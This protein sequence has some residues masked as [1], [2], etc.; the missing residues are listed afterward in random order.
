ME[1]ASAQ[2]FIENE[3]AICLNGDHI[4]LVKFRNSS[5]ERF[6]LV[7]DSLKKLVDKIRNAPKP[8]R[9]KEHNNIFVPF[10]PGRYFIGRHDE[11]ASLHNWLGDE[12]NYVPQAVALHGV[13]GVGKTQLAI[14][15][16]VDHSHLYEWV[17]FAN[18][19][20]AEVLRNDFRQMQHRVCESVD[21]DENFVEK[22]LAWL[23]SQED[24]WLLILDN[25]NHL[26]DVSPYLSRLAHRGHI[27]V[28]TQDSRVDENEFIRAALHVRSLTPEASQELLFAR[29]GLDPSNEGEA[30]AAKTL[31]AEI[32]HLPLA[33]DSAGAYMSVRRK[34]VTEYAS[35]FHEYQKELLDQPRPFSNYE[36][37]VSGALELN[38]KEIDTR[39]DASALLSLLIFLNRAEVTEAFL[40][41][42]VTSQLSWGPNG[43]AMTVT[44]QENYVPEALIKL[45]NNP[46]RLWDALEDLMSLS[47]ITFGSAEDGAG[48]SFTLHPLY[49]KCAKHRMSRDLRRKH[50]AE[51]L[52]FLAHAFPADEYILEKRYVEVVNTVRLLAH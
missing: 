33:I 37:S 40:K 22:I 16:A 10:R 19:A 30:E 4:N 15:Y 42:G 12:D 29:S 8:K 28:T 14:K 35:L 50:C 13:G 3:E 18:A 49:H 48:S 46:I 38:F 2:L 26:Q 23:T 51:A 24:R 20:S 17:F 9:M 52:L 43:E 47:I 31:L 39:P 21:K 41:R 36:R 7:F 45:I 5:D 25:A 44:P 6:R 11:L 27:I 34:S 32:G 1:K